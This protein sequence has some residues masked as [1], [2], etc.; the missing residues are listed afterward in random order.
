MNSVVMPHARRIALGVAAL[1][2][3]T[4][5]G[6][7][8]AHADPLPGSAP[9]SSTSS[10]ASAPAPS[11]TP[12]APSPGAPLAAAPTVSANTAATPATGTI[13]GHVYADANDNGVLNPG[14]GLAKVALTIYREG[15]G[16]Y[17]AT[18]TSGSGGTFTL[19]GVPGGSYMV[20]GQASGGWNVIPQFVTVQTAH[21]TSVTLRSVRPLGG[22]LHATLAFD[23]RVYRVGQQAVLTVTLHNSGGTALIGITAECNHVGDAD[24][25]Y[26]SG[27][28]WGALA[29]DGS[30]VTLG[31]GKSLTVRVPL[32]VPTAAKQLGS[33]I[34]ACDFGYSNVEES[35][36]PMARAAAAVPG[37]VSTV[38]VQVS[39]YRNGL[40]G[41][42]VGLAGVRLLIVNTF[43]CPFTARG[44]TDASG[45][46]TFTHVPVG[47]D[48][49]Y[50]YS[51]SG[52]KTTTPNPAGGQ[53]YS[54][55]TTHLSLQ[56]VPGKAPASTPPSPVSIDCT[57]PAAVQSS[58]AGPSSQAP[59]AATGSDTGL[60]AAI[61]G[62]LTIAGLGLTTLGAGRRA[63]S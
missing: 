40:Q 19:T 23:K 45:T 38:V 53:V 42:G 25:V 22:A 30:G 43:G 10:A 35:D 3:S 16:N 15:G 58:T 9:A 48:K 1:G 63:R 61:G 21:T 20:T 11:T 50:V 54:G 5:L 12:A 39:G 34:A 55:G 59:I 17:T 2:V 24:E 56:L 31:A 7:G 4:V 26:A 27:P 29:T 62:A 33:Y 44:T 32:T 57:N 8:A 14:E 36:R 46:Y 18:A 6:A 41:S 51:P 37:D 28:G 52:W 13:S 47:S 60:L 49:I